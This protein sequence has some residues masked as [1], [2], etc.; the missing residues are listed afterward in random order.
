MKYSTLN[1]SC[2]I[3]RR[4]FR[5]WKR[6]V[7]RLQEECVAFQCSPRIFLNEAPLLFYILQFNSQFWNN[8]EQL[9]IENRKQSGMTLF[10]FT[11]LHDCSRNLAPF[12]LDQSDAKLEPIMT[13]S[14]FSRSLGSL[15][16]DTLKFSLA[17]KGIFLS[18]DWAVI[19]SLVLV[20]DT[21]EKRSF[22]QY[23]F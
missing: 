17:L 21:I 19:V 20:Y 5:Y 3:P 14:V 22:L 10:S 18:P 2:Y 12:S 1:I 8:L 9:S 7:N 15:V 11:S 23:C 6:K 16:V 13:W 4:L